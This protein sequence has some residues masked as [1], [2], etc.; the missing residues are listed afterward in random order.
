[1]APYLKESFYLVAARLELRR[2]DCWLQN[3]RRR[4]S[5]HLSSSPLHPLTV[6]SGK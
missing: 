6:H 3:N 4:A 2:H 5:G 1:M